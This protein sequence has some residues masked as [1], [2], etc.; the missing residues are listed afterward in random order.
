[1]KTGR[2]PAVLEMIG[3]KGNRQRLW[4]AIRHH[5]T[6]TTW[7]KR[8]VCKAARVDDETANSYFQG[9]KAAGYIEIDSHSKTDRHRGVVQG[10]RS[11][12]LVRDIGAEAPRLRR[13]GEP[14][15]QGLAQEQMWRT[16]RM[17]KG[18]I[19]PRELAAHA[20]TT[21]ATVCESAARDYLQSLHLAGYLTITRAEDKHAIAGTGT[22]R[23]QLNPQRN[24]GP[25]PPMVCRTSAV[26]DPNENR[27]VWQKP[28][29]EE[30][31]IYGN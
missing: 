29:T 20:T 27:I 8:E 2:K 25:R 12:R 10:V 26:F 18:D 30:D 17:L 4:D 14:V 22:R 28:V 3:G 31:A 7:T 6:E 19:N 13:N 9:L 1:M 11:Y 5:G 16:L 21:A 24:T 15:T 23:Y